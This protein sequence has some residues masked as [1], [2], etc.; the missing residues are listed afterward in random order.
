[1]EVI[2]LVCLV[3]VLFCTVGSLLHT[4]TCR[5]RSKRASHPRNSSLNPVISQHLTELTWEILAHASDKRWCQPAALNKNTVVSK[6]FLRTRDRM[7]QQLLVLGGLDLV[8]CNFQLIQVLLEV[9]PVGAIA[10]Q[11][12]KAS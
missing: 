1:M 5:Y 4:A 2:A 11:A 8:L 9:A 3:P 10:R 12:G 6:L 7:D